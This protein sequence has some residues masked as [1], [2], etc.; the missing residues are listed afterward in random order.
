MAI[1]QP[2]EP[3]GPP[4]G[5]AARWVG[6][7]DVDQLDP[8]KS[9]LELS[10]AGDYRLARLLLRRRGA[11]LGYATVPITAGTVPVA[12]VLERASALPEPAPSEPL[13]APPP[14]SVVVCTR[15]RPALLRESLVPLL[16]Q[17]Y[18]SFEVIVVDN[19]PK[20]S[21]TADV[22]AEFHVRY[23][24]EPR[25]GLSRARNAGL[26]VAHHDI[27]AFTD[28]DTAADSR[29]LEGIAR[30]FTR[31]PDV[32]CVSGPVPSGEL[33][34]SVQAYF[35]ARVT[36][37]KITSLRVFRL[38]D[39]PTDLPMFP[40]NFGQFGTGANHAVRASLV[41]DLGNY[42]EALGMGTRSQGGE[43]LDMFVRVLFA[44]HTLVREPSAIMW[45][46]HRDDTDALR[47][48]V[49]GY[50]RGLGALLTK[51]CLR[52]R[53]LGM[54]LARAPRGLAW[55]LNPTIASVDETDV[56]EPDPYLEAEGKRARRLELAQFLTGPFAYA[57]GR[58]HSRRPV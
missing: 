17:D 15:E 3:Y 37:S 8:S 51:L 38:D 29:W 6:L 22:A 44:G 14:I 4:E 57:E 42:D 2:M 45:H 56:V 25:V 26:A 5:P 53:I 43:D 1:S 30:G 24:V 21:G 28:D 49:V 54:A 31:A 48:Q 46:R 16:A 52:P 12:A 41:S 39:P 18:P 27:V 40:F 36:W 7:V 32:A 11:V 13:S 55:L 10:D 34:N 35:D 50:G 20:S 19:A 23:V 33:R 58:W 47:K 9:T